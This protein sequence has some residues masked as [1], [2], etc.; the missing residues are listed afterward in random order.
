MVLGTGNAKVKISTNY[1]NLRFH[2][3]YGILTSPERTTECQHQ[4]TEFQRQE[5]EEDSSEYR[6]VEHSQ[7]FFFFFSNSCSNEWAVI[8]YSHPFLCLLYTNNPVYQFIGKNDQCHNDFAFIII[9]IT[10]R[11]ILRDT[12]NQLEN[13]HVTDMSNQIPFWMPNIRYIG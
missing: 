7:S 13:K 1:F 10:S 3:R 2:T 4:T 12:L 6:L 11:Q 8:N 5:R 9:I